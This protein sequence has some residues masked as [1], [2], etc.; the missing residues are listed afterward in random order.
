MKTILA[1]RHVAEAETLLL[2]IGLTRGERR[3]LY[4]EKLRMRWKLF[5]T[6]WVDIGMLPSSDE[7]RP[8][9]DFELRDLERDP[10]AR[11]QIFRALRPAVVCWTPVAIQAASAA[12]SPIERLL[13]EGIER[14]QDAARQANTRIARVWQR[15]LDD[16]EAFFGLGPFDA[17][18]FLDVLEHLLTP[19]A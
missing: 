15:S 13:L 12:Y 19:G 2:L 8:T 10:G 9:Y 3:E 11:G 17:V 5:R 6:V 18:L 1:L 16:P 7:L 14:D 4:R